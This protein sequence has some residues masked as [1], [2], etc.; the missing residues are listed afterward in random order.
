MRGLLRREPA[1]RAR[2]GG[3]RS[4]SASVATSRRSACDAGQPVGCRR[5][6]RASCSSSAG[7]ALV[8]RPGGPRHAR[9][10]A[11]RSVG[12][13]GARRRP[14]AASARGRGPRRGPR[15]WRRHRAGTEPPAV[16]AEAVAVAGDDRRRR[17]G[18]GRG[19]RRP[20]SH[21][22]RRSRP[23]S[24]ASSRRSTTSVAVG[25]A[26]VAAH[27]SPC[28]AGPALRREP[29]PSGEHRAGER[30]RVRA[31]RGRRRAASTVVDH[32]GGERLAGG[33]LEAPLPAVVDLDQVEQACRARRRRRRALGTGA[34]PG[35]VERQGERLGAGGP[36]VALGVG[37]A[38]GA[39][40]AATAGLGARRVH[41]SARGERGRQR[42]PRPPRRRRSSP[43]SRSAS[44]SSRARLLARAA[45][46][47]APT[48]AISRSVRA[49]RRRAARRARPGP[50]AAP[51]GAAAG[52][53][54]GPPSASNAARSAA[55]VGLA[56][57]SAS[58]LGR[59][60]GGFGLDVGEL[61]GQPGRLGL[62]RGDRRPASTQA[63][64][65]RSTP[66]RRSASTAASPRARSRS[67]SK[68]TSASPRSCAADAPPARASV[69]MHLGVERGRGVRLQRCSSVGELAPG[70]AWSLARRPRRAA[71]SRPARCSRRRVS[72]ATR[73]PWRR[74]A[75]AWRSSGRSWRRTSRSRSCSRSEVALGRVEAALGLLLA[76]AVLQDA[77]GL[78]D[79]QPAVLGPGVEHGVDL[80]LAARSRAAGGRR[81]CRTAAPGCRGAGTARR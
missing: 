81:R 49:R 12:L 22:R 54:V 19:R 73:S 1:R 30:R 70:A 77:G 78:L 31:R 35:V 6:R 42:A 62:E 14:S 45:P 74:A 38:A 15:P 16:T 5:E 43:R 7:D 20:P 60:R 57:S 28:R 59:Q 24:S 71:I 41:A 10:A 75:S 79:D 4:A 40:S 61:V 69:A 44:A 72:S 37:G 65:S 58:Q 25:D 17:D 48:R 11:P 21:R 2:R 46:R 55:S 23:P 27:G 67:D 63:P 56:P 3:E 68:R 50:R 39:C 51:A 18:R 80:A 26:D 47:R 34:G 76:A 52:H 13:D 53:A 9:R 33:R 64:R 36:R 8:A 32:D 29:A 66:R